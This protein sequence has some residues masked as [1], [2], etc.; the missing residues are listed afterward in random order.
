MSMIRT[1]VSERSIP[2][3]CG[4]GKIIKR[5]VKV[6]ETSSTWGTYQTEYTLDCDFCKNE[7][8]IIDIDHE[9]H[10]RFL[11]KKIMEIDI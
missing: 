11:L 2:C 3:P 7:G 4:R 6:F 1:P 10:K 9:S 5:E 8:Y